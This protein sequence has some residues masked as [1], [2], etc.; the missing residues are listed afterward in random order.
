[1]LSWFLTYRRLR[2][3]D[4][5]LIYEWNNEPVARSNSFN[6]SGILKEEHIQWFDK[7]MGDENAFY[8]LCSINNDPVSIVR[9]DV[10][11]NNTLIGI[12]IAPQYRGK[13]ISSTILMDTAIFY[14]EK[15]KKPVQAFIKPENKASICVFEKAGYQFIKKAMVNAQAALLY[16]LKLF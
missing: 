7:K 3:A 14:F 16:E 10:G 12:N 13:G 2:L 11:K 4:K 8:W 6:Q 5:W 1:M 9:Y 15:F